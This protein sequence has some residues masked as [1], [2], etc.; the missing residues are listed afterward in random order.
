MNIRERIKI[1]ASLGERLF[2]EKTH[3]SDEFIS[4]MEKAES[5]FSFFTSSNIIRSLDELTKLLDEE[6]LLRWTSRYK[7][8]NL[9]DKKIAVIMAG[10]LPF[11]GFHDVLCVLIAGF[12]VIIKPSSNDK[13]LWIWLVG[14]LQQVSSLMASRIEITY[15]PIK[16]FDVVIA[17]GSDNSARYFEE[18]FSSIPHIIRKNRTSV[19]VLAG[20]ESQDE[21]NLLAD[22]MFSYF[23]LGCRNVSHVFIPGGYDIKE[24]ASNLDCP[25]IPALKRHNS[26]LHNYEYCRTMALMNG[27]PH[28]DTGY[29]LWTEN[30][31]LHVP[32]AVV[33][34]S[35][36]N[37]L[38]S[39]HQHLSDNKDQ[40]QCIVSDIKLTIPTIPFG[41]AQSPSLA[42]Y[43]DGIDTMEWLSCL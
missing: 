13:Y 4:V 24:L 41:S 19:A 22:D 28:I 36:Y 5:K 3:V 17:T 34:Y 9:S 8:F 7:T 20:N 6:K 10:N 30:P 12:R 14:Q 38:Q 31:S 33:N 26:Y 40:I 16:N 42:D 25:A 35:Y 1:F 18:Y 23:G 39:L 37:N 2:T 11:V 15:N 27:T 32:T 43:A 21:L 29:C